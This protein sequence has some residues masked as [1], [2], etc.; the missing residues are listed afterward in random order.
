[1]AGIWQYEGDRLISC[2]FGG[3]FVGV[4]M[5]LIFMRKLYHRRRGYPGKAFAE[6]TAPIC[7]TGYAIMLVDF[8][9]VGASVLVF[10]EIEAA[11]VWYHFHCLHDTR[12]WIHCSMV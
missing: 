1:M 8:V 7:R 10:G 9:I 5:A 11:T 12:Q 4:G 3:I 6:A 2:G